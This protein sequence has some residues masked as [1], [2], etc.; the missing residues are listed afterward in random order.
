VVTAPPSP[1]SSLVQTMRECG[2]TSMY[3]PK[4]SICVE[5]SLPNTRRRLDRAGAIDGLADLR[6][7]VARTGVSTDR[8]YGFGQ[9]IVQISRLGSLSHLDWKP[10]PVRHGEALTPLPQPAHQQTRSIA[11]P[12]ESAAARRQWV[13]RC[14]S[15]SAIHRSR[16]TPRPSPHPSPS[17]PFGAEWRAAASRA[18]PPPDG[19]R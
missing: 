1:P 17:P 5:A 19:R 11:A 8:L 7:H 16:G 13:V 4:N 18:P 12:Q 15:P 2:V 3:R 9:I 10:S 6:L 14:P